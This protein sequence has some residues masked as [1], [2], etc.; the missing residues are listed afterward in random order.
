MIDGGGWWLSPGPAETDGDAAGA[1]VRGE[2][3]GGP[4]EARSGRADSHALRPGTLD[5]PTE[6]F[7]GFGTRAHKP[8]VMHS[9]FRSHV[10][11]S[12]PGLVLELSSERENSNILK[13]TSTKETSPPSL[14][15]NLPRFLPPALQSVAF[16]ILGLMDS[17]NQLGERCH[18]RSGISRD[19]LNLNWLR[20]TQVQ[21]MGIGFFTTH[22]IHL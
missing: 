21:S 11:K 5:T 22:F 19:G 9:G 3:D 4:R 17:L 12:A 13:R 6:S 1:G 7:C 14:L 16:T 20:Q 8:K 15:P 2:A 18:D 10:V